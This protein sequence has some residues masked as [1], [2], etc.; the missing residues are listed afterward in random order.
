MPIMIL[1]KLA[2]YA[3]G[4]SIIIATYFWI[5]NI[6]DENKILEQ[7]NITLKQ[8]EK[9]IIKAYENSIVVLQKKSYDEGMNKAQSLQSKTLEKKID[10]LNKKR[11]FDEVNNST[12]R[13]T[14]F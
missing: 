4:A 11:K 9:A 8:N 14:S 1:S 6:L 5:N 10:Q 7:N 12:Y 2:P 13:T 3:I